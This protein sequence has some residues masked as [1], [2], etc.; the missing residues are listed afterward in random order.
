M[1]GKSENVWNNQKMLW[2]I[3]KYWETLKMLRHSESVG[4]HLKM[5]RENLKVLRGK[6]KMNCLEKYEMFGEI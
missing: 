1:L 3:C 6:L 2:E 5:L 4:T